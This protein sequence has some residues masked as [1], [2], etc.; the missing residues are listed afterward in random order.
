MILM[1][2]EDH[3]RSNHDLINVL[4]RYYDEPTFKAIVDDLVVG[5]NVPKI[6]LNAK[7]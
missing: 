7:L 5:E 4:I 2:H 3:I 1:N 6:L